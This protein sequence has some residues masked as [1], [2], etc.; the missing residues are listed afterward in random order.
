MKRRVGAE[1]MMPE[2]CLSWNNISK[3]SMQRVISGCG[4]QFIDFPQNVQATSFSFDT[5]LAPA[6]SLTKGRAKEKYTQPSG[7]AKKLKS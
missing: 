3:L 5:F 4:G 1:G 6:L 7:C 2:I